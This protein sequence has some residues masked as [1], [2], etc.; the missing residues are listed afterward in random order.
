MKQRPVQG[1][2]IHR[3]PV[4]VR[5]MLPQ[6]R[7]PRSPQW[8]GMLAGVC[9]LCLLLSSVAE[10]DTVV[11]KSVKTPVSGDVKEISKTEVVVEKKGGGSEKVAAN[12]I[13]AISYTGEPGG[14]NIARIDENNG[15]FD[16]AIDAYKKALDGAKVEGLKADLSWAIAR[17]QGRMAL[18]DRSKLDEGIKAL[19]GFKSAHGD[20]YTYYDALK[21]LGDLYLVKQDYVKAQSTFDQLSKA[22]WPDYQMQAKIAAGR[23]KQQENKVDEALPLFEAV[24]GMSANNPQEESQRQAAMLGKA[25]ILIAKNQNDEAQTLLKEVLDKAAPDDTAVQAEAYVRQGDCYRAQ[26]KD[27]DALLAYLHVEVLF[28]AE[29]PLH[30]ESL[31]HLSKLFAKLGQMPRAA[32]HREKLEALYPTSDW[33]KQLKG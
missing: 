25:K 31:F 23:L 15:R 30:A 13:V 3:G 9:G 22:P 10:A 29:K 33:T 17:A 24:I 8:R 27:Q 16:K 19:E 20:H 4:V 14:L 18:T 12:D 26:N 6:S 21:L 32:E 28:S 5:S 11:R 1:A 7:S 2:V